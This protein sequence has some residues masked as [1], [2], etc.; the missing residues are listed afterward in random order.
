MSL[1]VLAFNLPEEREEHE[2][3]VNAMEYRSVLYELDQYLRSCVKHNIEGPQNADFADRI[4]QKLWSM[5]SE[6]CIEP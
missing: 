5:C 4:R 6:R 1:G 3:A 2:T